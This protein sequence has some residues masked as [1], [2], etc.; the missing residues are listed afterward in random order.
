MIELVACYFICGIFYMYL[1]AQTFDYTHL[2]EMPGMAI[3]FN[4]IQISAHLFRA[5][6]TWP[7]Y[8]IEDFALFNLN[9]MEGGSEE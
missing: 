9:R 5:G 2:D 7:L 8:I 3:F 1:E 4:C 6:L